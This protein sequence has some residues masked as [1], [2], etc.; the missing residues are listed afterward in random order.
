MVTRRK[1]VHDIAATEEHR[2]RQN[3]AA[4]G[5]AQNQ[6]VWMN[7]L[8]LARQQF[9]RAPESGLNF[10]G[11]QQHVV[12]AAQF[13][14]SFEVSRRRHDDATF[15]LNRFNEKRRCVFINGGLQRSDVTVF[16]ESKARRKRPESMLI[17]RFVGHRNDCYRATVK[18]A[19]TGDNLGLVGGDTFYRIGP[20]PR[21]LDSRLNG[22]RPGVHG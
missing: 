21:C 9:A 22:F 2:H 6:A 10:V 4:E 13:L 11:N 12:F 14:C 8:V 19:A 16:D 15:T 1:H 3:A 7:I 20:L 18:I 5:F 17:L